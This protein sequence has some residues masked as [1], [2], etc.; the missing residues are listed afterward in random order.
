MTQDNLQQLFNLLDTMPNPIALNE[1]VY[2]EE[3]VA[4]DKIIYLNKN[5]IKR[6]GYTVEDIPTDRIWFSKAYP[7]PDYRAYVSKGWFKEIEKAKKAGTDLS[8]FPAKIQCKSGE[9]KWFNVTTQ[10]N[11][12]IAEKYRTIVF[13]QTEA[14]EETKLQLDQTS[15]ALMQEQSLLKTIIN[16]API[17]IFWKNYEG[18]YLGCN[19][20]FLEDA[21]LSD[22]SEIIGKTDYDMVWKEEAELYRADD[23]EVC[24]TGKQKLNYIETQT[25]ENGQRIT[26]STS[27]V[28]LL[29]N[30]GNRVGVLGIYQDITQEYEAKE[31]LKEQE[32]M[33]LIQSRQAAMG[34]MISMIAHQ[35]RQP[36]STI[37]AV[38]SQIQVKHSLGKKLEEDI[39]EFTQTISTQVEYLS[40]TISD[41]SSFFKENREKD[42]VI[43]LEVIDKSVD[44]FSDL[45]HHKGIRLIKSHSSHSYFM[46]Y[47]NELQQVIINLIK[48]AVDALLENKI[49]T[50][51]IEVSS[52]DEEE[53]VIIKIADNAGGISEDIIDNIFDPYFST[54]EAKVETGLGLY[55]SKMII[56]KHLNGELSC[57]NGAE[58]AVFKITVPKV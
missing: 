2:D 16:T 40:Q 35:W 20:A 18:V 24:D 23:K 52:Y 36:L 53:M 46:T 22:E 43:A 58:G 19:K 10:L 55:M 21:N 34:E 28:P 47:S 5:F 44:I 37:A 4:F 32:K 51:W 1:L 56:E 27:K 50:K 26:V 31:A 15:I 8:G 42:K 7:D 33:I 13:V 17:R 29:D 30:L 41:F 25:H 38:V 39:E 14:P 49:E 54:K 6:I 11:H 48:N 45:L 9:Q 3:G 12:P 57:H